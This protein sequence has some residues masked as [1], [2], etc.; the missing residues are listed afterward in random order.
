M[1]CSFARGV[2]PFSS[3][4][5]KRGTRSNGL[6]M[7]QAF[8]S[9]GDPGD[10]VEDRGFRAKSPRP[11]VGA[12]RTPAPRRPPASPNE[13]ARRHDR[14][15]PTPVPLTGVQNSSLEQRLA[16]FIRLATMPG[17]NRPLLWIVVVGASLLGFGGVNCGSSGQFSCAPGQPCYCEGGTACLLDCTNID[18]CTPFCRS[19]NVCQVKCADHCNYDCHSIGDCDVATG[20]NSTVACGSVSSCTSSVGPGSTVDCDN[21]S[22]C[23]VTCAG[24]CAVHS[25]SVS[26]TRVTCASGAA[27]TQCDP[28]HW[29][30][31]GSC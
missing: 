23:T 20:A 28:T 31:D 1:P 15:N 3:A 13:H 22:S 8:E 18:A 27:A 10:A 4:V 30:C 9:S 14:P 25:V 17:V 7:R 5:C 29:V 12:L 19:T 26:S 24:A 11:A 2:A 21:M 6:G 16:L